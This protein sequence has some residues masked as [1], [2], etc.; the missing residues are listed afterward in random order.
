MA[1][2]PAYPPG[3]TVASLTAT[4]LKATIL[5]LGEGSH[6]VS[7]RSQDALNQWGAV[8][9]INL[10]MDQTGPVTSNVSAVPNPNNGTLGF[11]SSIAAV[12]VTASISDALS[13]NSNIVAGEG[14]I[15]TVGVDGKGFIFLPSDGLFNSSTENGYSDI[16]LTTIN[17]LSVAPHYLR[18]WQGCSRQLGYNI[19]HCRFAHRQGCAHLHQHLA[20]T[21]PDQWCAT[22]TL[23]VNGAATRVAAAFPAMSTGSARRPAPTRRPA[24]APSSME[25][26]STSC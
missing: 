6:V 7:V 17:A 10:V 23:T 16:P 21:K 3:A 5:A 25:R 26:R 8:A 1:V 20:C 9:T 19:W 12:R 24:A 2:S 13:G 14:F 11:N 22:V 15:D 4:I 18:A